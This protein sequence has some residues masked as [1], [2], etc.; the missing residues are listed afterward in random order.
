M[1]LVYLWVEKYKNIENQGFNFSPRF[2]CEFF[3]EY[4]EN[5]ILKNDCELKITPKD[6]ESIFPENI[7]ITAIVGKNGVGKSSIL[8]LLKYQAEKEEIEKPIFFSIYTEKK[9][10]EEKFYYVGTIENVNYNKKPISR[11][12]IIQTTYILNNKELFSSINFKFL[13]GASYDS[14]KFDGLK[15]KYTHR[16]NNIFI[17]KYI[18]LYKDNFNIFKKLDN[19][20]N[21]DVL[22]FKLDLNERF[23]KENDIFSKFINVLFENLKLGINDENDEMN[24]KKYNS[25]LEEIKIN[26]TNLADLITKLD[27][28]E[29]LVI[30]KN[31][32]QSEN[33]LNRLQIKKEINNKNKIKKVLKHIEKYSLKLEKTLRD[34]EN[35]IY[36]DLPIFLNNEFNKDIMDFYIF[37]KLLRKDEEL[38]LNQINIPILNLEL[39]DSKTS[40]TFSSISEGEKNFTRLII[41][42]LL[43]H[44]NGHLNAYNEFN[45][46]FLYDEVETSFHPDLQ[47]KVIEQSIKIFKSFPQHHFNLVFATHSPFILSDIPNK[48]V[49]FLEK[50]DEKDKEKLKIKYPK[51]NTKGLENGTCINVSKYIELKTF[52]ANIHTLLSNGFFMSDGLMGEFAKSKIRTIQITYKYISHRNKQKSLHK[53]EHKKSR[54]FIRTQLKT[55]WYIQSIIGEKFLQTIMKNY[56]QE[57]EEILFGNEKA[58]DNEIERLQNLRKSIKNAKN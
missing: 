2:E 5:G 7:N 58:I 31:S 42:N 39:Y 54:R 17:P 56:L 51:L 36:I 48:N 29:K 34:D 33:I 47:K 18:I 43:H 12:S 3:P 11:Y 22:R 38:K 52:G 40:R 46:L 23:L 35:Y 50:N 25:K 8:Q 13:N 41:E 4:N 24:R 9:D 49:I 30:L 20:I 32:D 21:F 15:Y 28:L 44:D 19:F 45:T 6:Y 27:S 53:K 57:I 26:T 10:Q 37:Q 16:D 55:F 1:E 14:S